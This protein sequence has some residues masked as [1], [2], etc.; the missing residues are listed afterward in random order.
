[1][2]T[3]EVVAA[4]NVAHGTDYTVVRRL[5]G[6]LQ[7]G[8]FEVR[9]SNGRAVLKWSA[10]TAWA[11]RVHRAAELI[12]R[13]RAVGW[14]TPAWLLVGTT[15]AGAPYQVQEYVD[16][17]PLRDAS[18][19]GHALA[20]DLIEVCE[21]QRGL[22]D[23]RE[24][25][26]SDYVRGVVFEGWDEMWETVRRFDEES[27]ELIAW[28]DRVC[29]PY[30]DAELPTDDLVHGD[31]NVGNLILTDDGRLAGIIDLEAAS[32][33][34]RAYDLV[35][36]ASSASRDG[37]PAGVDERFFEAALRAGGFATTA[38]CAASAYA[39]T[40]EFVRRIAP[41]NVPLV[42]RGGR[43]MLELLEAAAPQ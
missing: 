8:A 22:V 31:L 23:D 26:W 24:V 29:R 9:G 20:D 1:V 35:S 15:P 41:E 4:V 17:R 6:G 32:G 12:R 3:G 37:A 7:S 43:R 5:T 36:L 18:T 33:G 40:L 30:R 14:P 28:Y 34:S 16:G 27:A 13:A 25:S 38:V 11:P 19:I 10:N 39:S 42:Q 21:L 2:Q